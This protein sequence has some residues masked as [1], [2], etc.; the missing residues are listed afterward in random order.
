MLRGAMAPF[1]VDQFFGVFAAYNTAIWPMQVVLLVLAI[2]AIGLAFA[3]LHVRS[4]II[5]GILAALWLW[6]G[7]VYHLIFFSVINPAAAIFGVAF[8]L[9]A[10]LLIWA[11]LGPRR[12]RFAFRLDAYGATGAALLAY[13]LILYPLLGYVFGHDYPAIPTFGAPCPT[14]IFTF[15]L[16]LWTADRVP[17]WLLVI[18][19]L[20][21]LIGLSA[22][23]SLNVPQDL[24]LL[25]AGVIAIPMLLVRGRRPAA[26]HQPS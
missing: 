9:E 3:R 16:L 5:T 10:A 2:A 18:P 4:Q 25:A 11:G 15:G 17:W 12:L 8:A 26:T 14:T 19:G 6:M 1:T 21:A 22:A 24:G 23:L 13:A 7:L 20:W